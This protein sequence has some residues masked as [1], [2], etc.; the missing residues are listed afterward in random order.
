MGEVMIDEFDWA[1]EPPV[2]AQNIFDSPLTF[3]TEKGL[4]VIIRPPQERLGPDGAVNHGRDIKQQFLHGRLLPQEPS[5]VGNWR[6]SKEFVQRGYSNGI[7]FF[8][9]CV[10][11]FKCSFDRFCWKASGHLRSYQALFVDG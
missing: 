2:A 6:L 10:S 9:L 3:S 4:D 7:N 8:W 11:I 5:I 1:G